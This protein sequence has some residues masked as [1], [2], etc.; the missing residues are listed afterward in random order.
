VIDSFTINGID[1]N[2]LLVNPYGVALSLFP[3]T[4]LD[5]NK[6]YDVIMVVNWSITKGCDL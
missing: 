6:I 1:G 2:K 5:E 4:K 3:T